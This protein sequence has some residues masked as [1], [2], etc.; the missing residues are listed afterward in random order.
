MPRF[1]AH[2]SLLFTEVP[3]LDRFNAAAACGFKGVDCMYPYEHPAN[4]V[5]DRCSMAGVTMVVINT[6]KGEGEDGE[7]GL[8][9]VRG[10][11]KEFRKNITTALEYCDWLDCKRLHVMA[12]N[13]PAE[14]AEAALDTY[15]SNL[16]YAASRCGDV[17]VTAMI[18]ALYRDNYFLQRPEQAVTVIEAVDNKN[19]KLMYDV[20]HA[21]RG[22]GGI[23]DFIENNLGLIEHIQI[24]GVPDRHEPDAMSELNWPYLFDL[25]DAH[26]YDGWVGA[27][28]NP[29]GRT[30]DGLGWAK[31]WGIQKP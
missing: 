20:F 19:L 3:L 18:E 25:L 7:M 2:I 24:A 23:A 10:R 16:S 13:V 26:G 27:E 21:Q 4:D 22:Q 1:S 9:A 29:R 30:E 5:A 11:E 6:P 8:A 17:G 12:G 28:Y 14:D 15:I 31:D